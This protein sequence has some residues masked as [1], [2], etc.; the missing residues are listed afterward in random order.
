MSIRTLAR[1]GAAA[2]AAIM[3]VAALLA[4]WA[5]NEIRFGGEMHRVNQQ[6]NDF[7]AD[8]LPPPAYLI[9]AYLEAN[10]LAREPETVATR[11]KRLA[12]LEQDFNARSD[13]WAASDLEPALRE[14]FAET[15]RHD[16]LPFWAAVKDELIPAA[17]LRD[18]AALDAAADKLGRIYAGHRQHIDALVEGAAA[19]QAQLAGEAET[20][21]IVT[22]AVLALAGLM[23]GGSVA[24]GLWFLRGR[25]IWPLYDI[26]VVM[27]RM[28]GGDL[29]AGEC[30][31]HRPDE[32]GTM[33]RTI[34]VF[35]ASARAER[36]NAL[37]QQQVVDALG[38][39]LARLAD[40]DLAYRITAPLA[41]EY[42]ALRKGY[43]ASAERLAEMI[44]QVRA[45]A[46]GVSTGAREIHAASDDLATRNQRQ[47][48]SLEE[49]AATM[50]QVTT[51]VR[52]S[53]D[54][55][56]RVR[57]AMT[58]THDRATEG[59]AVVARAVAAMGRIEA[60]S[61]EIGQILDII[62]AIAFQTNLLALNAGVEAARAGSA[63]AG[64]AVVATEVRAL[65]Q[66][67]AD[68][69]QGIK[70][71]IHTS[72]AEVAD[73]V[74]L[75]GETGT[76]LG[77]IVSRLGEVTAGVTEIAEAAAAQATSLAQINAA[78]GDMDRMTQQNA[79]MV[80]EA[81]A[82]ANSLAAEAGD[83]GALVGRFRLEGVAGGSGWQDWRA[84]A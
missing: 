77:A 74:A 70:A 44:G 63:G 58:E 22:A 21:I 1:K 18:R 81:T 12:K 14:G 27:E 46:D 83:L 49:T 71:L 61:R 72:S 78:V 60:S 66:R 57:A 3:V 10:L 39:A 35:R 51:L 73:G 64:F 25:V 19:H 31:E 8:I 23:V 15:A 37:K 82:A 79:A 38:A 53:A 24:A 54:N 9:E 69:A 48:A 34:E 33:T 6:L 36:D 62:D 28:A 26:S 13:H 7:N 42:E 56:G 41:P 76:L 68:A 84:A 43:N 4:G 2:L 80:E 59:G 20:T 52:D 50:N 40:C 55:A 47:A 11:A 16:A 75:V 17:H 29:D 45:S 32:T 5:I 65:A 67:S 30:H